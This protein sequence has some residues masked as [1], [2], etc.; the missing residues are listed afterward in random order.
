MN[1]RVFTKCLRVMLDKLGVEN[2]DQD[3]TVGY[4]EK[5]YPSEVNQIKKNLTKYVPIGKTFKEAWKAA[6]AAICQERSL[7][8]NG[9][10]PRN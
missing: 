3:Q 1:N 9:K 2:N 8:K 4:Y 10:K 5:N 7:I 6:N